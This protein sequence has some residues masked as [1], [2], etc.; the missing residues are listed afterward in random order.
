M[1]QLKETIKQ[2][3]D[4]TAGASRKKSSSS[5]YGQDDIYRE[6]YEQAVE[7]IA[8]GCPS[9]TSIYPFIEAESKV[10]NKT[11]NQVAEEII[12]KRS[13]WMD[14]MVSIEE[15]RLKGKFEVTNATTEAEIDTART[16]AITALQLI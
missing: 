12:Q 8:G 16:I 14:K 13:E 9:D 15:I 1:E 7:F 4:Q 10:T 11:P 2:Y 6:K 5:V 3:I